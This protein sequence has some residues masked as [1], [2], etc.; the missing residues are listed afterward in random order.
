MLNQPYNSDK[1]FIR[2]SHCVHYVYVIIM[3]SHVFN[4]S[5]IVHVHCMYKCT[6]IVNHSH[7]VHVLIMCSHVNS[8]SHS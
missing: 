3:C 4:R 7:C 8:R 5:H 1:Q 6:C 2:T